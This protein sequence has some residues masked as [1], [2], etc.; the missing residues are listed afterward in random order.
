[1]SV[2][3]SLV[4][5]LF[6]TRSLIKSLVDKT[7]TKFF[8]KTNLRQAQV[9]SE[10]RFPLPERSVVAGGADNAAEGTVRVHR[11]C[12]E[13]ALWSWLLEEGFSCFLPCLCSGRDHAPTKILI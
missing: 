8:P 6:L 2:L 1:M 11:T 9:L 7:L 5:S 13:S 12:V 3:V 10:S 4:F